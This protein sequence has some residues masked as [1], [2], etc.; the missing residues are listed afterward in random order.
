MSRPPYWFTHTPLGEWTQCSGKDFPFVSWNQH[1]RTAREWKPFVV[2]LELLQFSGNTKKRSNPRL[3]VVPNFGERQTSERDT[4][5]RERLGEHA[6]FSED[7]HVLHACTSPALFFFAEIRGYLQ[8]KATFDVPHNWCTVCLDFRYCAQAGIAFSI[9]FSDCAKCVLHSWSQRTHH[10]SRAWEKVSWFSEN[11][12]GSNLL[13]PHAPFSRAWFHHPFPLP[14]PSFV[15]SLSR[16]RYS[17]IVGDVF[18]RA[19]CCLCSSVS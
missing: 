14:S 1:D 10:T 9:W 19:R 12:A 13:S 7:T 11:Y 18:S 3:Q 5:V 8:S 4:R 6:W 15:Y 17:L 16:H 2:W